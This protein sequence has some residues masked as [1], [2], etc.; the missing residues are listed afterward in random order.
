MNLPENEMQFGAS[1]VRRKGTAGNGLRSGGLTCSQIRSRGSN[2][3]IGTDWSVRSSARWSAGWC[4]RWSVD[5][6]LGWNVDWSAGWSIARCVAWSGP[7]SGRWNARSGAYSRRRNRECKR[8]FARWIIQNCTNIGS[9]NGKGQILPIYGDCHSHPD[10]FAGAIQSWP[11]RITRRACRGYL[12]K[13]AA[14]DCSH[15][16]DSPLTDRVGE[17]LWRTNRND[18]L[19]NGW[20]DQR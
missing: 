15:S 4:P 2:C 16:A 12:N 8:N 13:V 1:R 7:W 17:P 10:Y 20:G 19:P 9:R 11:T 6:S 3:L 18:L 5:R 14:S